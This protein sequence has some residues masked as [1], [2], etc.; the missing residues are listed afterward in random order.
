MDDK[1]CLT[2]GRNRLDLTRVH[3]T[4]DS[5]GVPRLTREVSEHGNSENFE[6]LRPRRIVHS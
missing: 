6:T 5:E 1:L 2:F 4:F 3:A